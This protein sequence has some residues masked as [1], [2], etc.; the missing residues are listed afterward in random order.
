M[1]MD[2]LI[3]TRTHYSYRQVIVRCMAERSPRIVARCISPERINYRRSDR[4][5]A[6]PTDR[7]FRIP[8]VLRHCEGA[9]PGESPIRLS[10]VPEQTTVVFGWLCEIKKKKKKVR[11]V[12]EM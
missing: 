6:G 4:G 8:Q 7:I 5:D 10:R 2:P 1:R 3:K 9:A 12:R 11:K